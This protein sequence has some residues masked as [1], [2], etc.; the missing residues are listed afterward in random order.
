MEIKLKSLIVLFK[1]YASLNKN[2]KKSLV[3][4]E[5]SVNEFTVMEA[6]S[7]KGKLTTQQLID[8]ILIPNSS[9]TYVLDVLQ[10]K[11]YITRIKDKDD[12]RKQWLELTSL[13]SDVFKEIYQIHYEHMSSIFNVLNEQEQQDLQR[14]LKRIG[15]RAEEKLNETY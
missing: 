13:G 2:V 10:K 6:L 15:Q 9:M 14:Y 7:T 11:K 4:T 5:L 3:D 8:I 12:K 1:A